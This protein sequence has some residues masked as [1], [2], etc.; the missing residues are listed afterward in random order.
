MTSRKKSGSNIELQDENK[1]AGKSRSPKR[2]TS[3]SRSGSPGKSS[4][5]RKKSSALG[6]VRFVAAAVILGIFAFILLF[7]ISR[8]STNAMMPALAKNDLVVSWA[9]PF[10]THDCLPGRIVL[11][12]NGKN[13][14]MSNYL[15]A[16]ACNSEDVSF[17]S[18]RIQINGKWLERLRLTNDAIVR[19]MNEPEIWREMLPNGA[20][21]K[22][23]LPQHAI[24]GKLQGSLKA[25]KGFFAV[26]DNRMASYDSRQIGLFEPDLIRGH[27]LFVLSSTRNDGIIAG[28]FKWVD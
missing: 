20:R 8:V 13:E 22:I 12:N 24:V 2:K 1:P 28:L 10:V 3:K 25:D 5:K 14:S 15:R 19:P 21:Y 27:V 9:P 11:I 26:G 23:M 6:W 18:D 16:I 17:V 7:D 4:R